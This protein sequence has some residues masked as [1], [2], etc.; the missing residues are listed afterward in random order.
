MYSA[1]VMLYD[2]EKVRIK[3]LCY[4]PVKGVISFGSYNSL[5]NR[6]QFEIRIFTVIYNF[7]RDK[8]NGC[9]LVMYVSN[10]RGR[11]FHV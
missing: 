3:I 10:S 4:S 9:F 6:F 2:A 5:G 11:E 1:L 7:Y 8:D